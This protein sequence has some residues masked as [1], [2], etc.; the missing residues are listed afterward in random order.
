MSIDYPSAFVSSTYKDLKEH[1]TYV[2]N[3]LRHCGVR[4][5]PMEEW[6]AAPDAPKSF[7]TTRIEGCD[8]F[9]LLV[10]NR[11]GHIPKGEVR[12]IT[13]LEYDH[14][15][16]LGID[17]L[18]FMLTN[19]R[20]SDDDSLEAPSYKLDEE[21][22]DA[23][24]EEWRKEICEQYGVG[25][26]TRPA[27]SVPLATSVAR[28]LLSRQ[29][30]LPKS[31]S[32]TA[33]LADATRTGDVRGFFTGRFDL[34]KLAFAEYFGR[35]HVVPNFEV[36]TIQF[37]FA[38]VHP[39]PGWSQMP[40]SITYISLLDPLER[41]LGGRIVE[42]MEA[43]DRF[44]NDSEGYDERRVKMIS[45]SLASRED[46]RDLAD[47]FFSERAVLVGGRR[48]LLTKKELEIMRSRN[49]V[50]GRLRIKTWDAVAEHLDGLFATA[51]GGQRS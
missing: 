3:Q 37:D 36:G 39:V 9:V 50:P 42:T 49:A 22:R 46:Y 40:P 24:V 23:T 25:F 34:V 18:P 31:L 1:R 15:R 32:L 48:S 44:L 43:I 16:R 27:E 41:L 28:W 4:V 2:I 6:D 13:Q 38:I 20:P 5:D 47:S 45:E 12:S 19:Q 21:H 8:L 7:S 51:Q 11:L 29:L 26:F 17:I 10:G 33:I 35:E 14:A 30:P